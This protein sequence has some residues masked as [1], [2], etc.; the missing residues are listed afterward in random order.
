MGKSAIDVLSSLNCDQQSAN[1]DDAPNLRRRGAGTKRALAGEVDFALGQGGA[2]THDVGVICLRMRA[3][4]CA[5]LFQSR[6][7][8]ARMIEIADNSR[9]RGE[10]RQIGGRPGVAFV[11]FEVVESDPTPPPA[12]V[13]DPTPAPALVPVAPVLAP[14]PPRR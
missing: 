12:P 7:S 14:T 10:A 4:D 13:L 9:R 8:R 6:E 5:S 1:V 3:K 11:P 2:N